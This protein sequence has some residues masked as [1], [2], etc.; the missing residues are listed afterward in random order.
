MKNR[1]K[2]AS[3]MKKNRKRIAELTEEEK[4]K[5]RKIWREEKKQ[6]KMKKLNKETRNDAPSTSKPNQIEAP[7]FKN[8]YL[9]VRRMYRRALNSVRSLKTKNE[10]IRKKLYREKIAQKKK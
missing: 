7:S 10:T 4:D 5:R 8:R 6:Q 3:K 9:K 1:K 2:K